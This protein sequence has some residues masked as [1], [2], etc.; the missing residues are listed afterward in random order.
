LIWPVSPSIFKKGAN[1][2]GP[3]DSS[4]RIQ[5]RQK[6]QGLKASNSRPSPTRA[7]EEPAG[8]SQGASGL[9]QRCERRTEALG[10]F[11]VAAD[12][13]YAEPIAALRD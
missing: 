5:P 6:N 12:I 2:G 10:I 4:D 1:S 7:K 13:S 11:H 9:H 8:L 3:P